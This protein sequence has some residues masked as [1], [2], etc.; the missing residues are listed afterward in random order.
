M[1]YTLS[2]KGGSVMP[3]GRFKTKGEAMAVARLLGGWRGT[4]AY[5]IKKVK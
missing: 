5:E 4:G 2:L 1:P 3:G